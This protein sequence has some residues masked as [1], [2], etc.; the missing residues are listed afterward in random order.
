MLIEI[1]K[2]ARELLWALLTMA[3]TL[4]EKLRAYGVL[5]DLVLEVKQLEPG[6][7]PNAGKFIVQFRGLLVADKGYKEEYGVGVTE[8]EAL[9]DYA[10]RIKG[11]AL[12]RLYITFSP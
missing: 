10:K 8:I 5:N 11:K 12:L 4:I 9:E 6:P 2:L 3:N 7:E 1:E